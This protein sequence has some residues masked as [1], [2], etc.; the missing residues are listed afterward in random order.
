[1][2]FFDDDAATQVAGP[3]PRN[4]RRRNSPKRTRYQ[5]LAVFLAVAIVVIVGLSLWVNSC[6]H[7]RKVKSYQTYLTQVSK[8]I[9][10]SNELGKTLNKIIVSPGR[11]ESKTKLKT[12]IADLASK[13]SEIAQRVGGIKPPDK[14]RSEHAVLVDGMQVRSYGFSEMNKA[15]LDALAG[16]KVSAAKIAGLAAYLEGP[17]AYYTMYFYTDAQKTMQADGVKGVAVPQQ[18]YYM[19]TRILDAAAVEAMLGRLKETEKYSGSGA[20]GVALKTVTAAPDGKTL[21]P[22]EV[23]TVQSQDTA[24]TFTVTVENQGTVTETEVPVEI[25]LSVKGVDP[26]IV[27]GTIPVIDAGKQGSIELSLSPTG[28][29][30]SGESKLKVMAGPVKTEKYLKNNSRTYS[31]AVT[32][33]Q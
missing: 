32:F 28:D 13:Q 17:D 1:M 5:R 30:L 21:S 24:L 18:N 2:D 11:Y 25:T 10:D 15:M 27:T 16:K 12:A 19:T 29:V 9:D 4:P 20:R 33:Q 8:A 31:I 23:T 3:G 26:I 22:T 7:N 6:Q 14:L